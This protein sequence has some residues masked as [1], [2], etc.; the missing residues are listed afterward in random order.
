[1]NPNDLIREEKD[2]PGHGEDIL[3]QVGTEDL[4]AVTHKQLAAGEAQMRSSLD[5]L[6]IRK[7]ATMYWRVSLICIAASFCAALDGYREL[8]SSTEIPKLSVYRGTALRIDR[9]Q[10]G[11]RQAH[12]ASWTK[13]YR[14]QVYFGLGRHAQHWSTPGSRGPPVCG[15]SSGPKMG[16]APDLAPT[17]HRER[18]RKL[19]LSNADIL[20]AV[21][22]HRVRGLQLALLALCQ[23]HRWSWSGHDAA[24]IPSVHCRARPNPASR[25]PHQLLPFVSHRGSVYGLC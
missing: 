20:S 23:A 24:H 9:L 12:G 22:R 8:S 4:A 3:H 14:C 13:D 21:C 16:N 25:L 7:A 11:L 19:M 18:D 1:M 10:Q 6:P 5:N 2:L 15:R 17:R